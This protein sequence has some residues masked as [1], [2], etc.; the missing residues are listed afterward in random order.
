MA[1][2]SSIAAGVGAAASAGK[3]IAGAIKGSKKKD[4]KSLNLAPSSQLEKVAGQMS[5]EELEQ[6]RSL[7]GQGPGAQDIQAGLGAQR[8]FASSLSQFART[9]SLGADFEQGAR[10]SAANL[11]APERQ[12]LAASFDVQRQ[13]TAQLAAQ[14]G[15]SQDDPILQ[16]KLAQGQI[17]QEAALGARETA[18]AQ[19]FQGQQLAA[20]G[21]SAELQ[22]ALGQQALQNRLTLFG[23]GQQ[24]LGA[25]RDFRLRSAGS[26]TTS[27]SGGG[28][29]DAVGG[30]FAGAA[31]G[32]GTGL[33]IATQ[34]QDSGIF[35]GGSSPGVGNQAG[36]S[37]FAGALA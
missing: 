13:R 32:L 26:T 12:Q 10:R 22:A 9:G 21:Q 6:I 37:I 36:G 18:L 31:A 27:G 14:L 25:E 8:D 24:A 4:S 20:L 33:N 34:V 28:F 11:L 29:L 17:Q 15:R 23:A 1:A 30:G 2:F 3:G 16:A 35:S 5:R 19:Q 7:V